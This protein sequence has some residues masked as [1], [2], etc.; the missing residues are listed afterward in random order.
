MGVLQS[1][2][3]GGAGSLYPPLIGLYAAKPRSGKSSVATHLAVEHGYAKRPFAGPLKRMVRQ[4]L[5]EGGL[6]LSFIDRC[7]EEG[8]EEALPGALAAFGTPRRL[9][10]TLGTEWGRQCLGSDVWVALWRCGV[11]A[12]ERCVADDVRFP[13]EAQAIRDLGGEVWLIVRDVDVAAETLSHASE[14]GL[15]G[16]A[17][18][19]Y[20]FN[21]GTLAELDAAVDMALWSYAL[22]RYTSFQVDSANLG[23]S[24]EGG[25]R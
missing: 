17:F 8:K 5:R 18:D 20:V 6:S 21:T 13:N 3:A 11:Y 25:S 24:G 22:K 10:Q 1:G 4:F 14:G 7:M 2:Q 15:D 23:A 9:M 16:F 12:G 19:K